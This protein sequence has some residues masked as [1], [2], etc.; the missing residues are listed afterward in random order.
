MTTPT[1]PNFDTLKASVRGEIVFPDS[2]NFDEVRAIWNGMISRRPSV[3]VRCSGV[4]DV[5]ACLAFAKETGMEISVRGAGHNI[6]GTAIADN[7]LMV[8]L[9]AL[10]AVSVNPD[11]NTVT[12]G[13]G[14]ML[15]DID[16]ETKEFG[17]AVPTGINSTTGIS[18]L[19]LGGGIGW[20]T[21]KHGMTSDNL[22]SVQIVTAGGDVLEA[23][24]TENSDLFWAL[25]GGGGN[26]GIVT[27]WTFQAHPM[28]MV[29]AGLI[30]FPAEER[31]T[32]LQKYREYAPTLPL[33]T[34]VWVV[35]RKAPPLPFLLEEV[36]GQDVL[37]LALCHN[38]DAAEGQGFVD[39][40]K[41]F[42]N[43][44]GV[45]AGEMPFAGWQQAFDPLLTE[46]ARNYWK[47]HNFTDLSDP[48][49]DTMIEY[50]SALPHPECEIFFAHIE[51]VCGSM[52]PEATAYSHR[53]TKYVVNMHGRWR[54]EGD[55]EFCI[56]W[57]RDLFAA[58]KPF[59]APGVYINF[60]TSE[61]TDRIKDGFGPNYDR[62]LAIKSKYDPDNVFNLNQNIVPP[63]K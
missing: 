2:S 52:A 16:H 23:S 39:T 56:Q 34:A 29:T 1:Q 63:E 44:V 32:V 47:S 11:T 26:F 6:A 53:H 60:M 50:A 57:A 7:R 38:G 61:E 22:L 21:R 24:E 62:L 10:R 46:G 49:L 3:I 12:A 51:G 30:V 48:F 58:T 41:S 35:L 20:M 36:H 54:E 59:A 9:S 4:A 43:P 8:D 14:T 37:V 15:G 18:G 27:R 19:A 13:P 25:R 17:L 33:G 42:G 45:H 31:M 40:L 55:D 5:K 28:S